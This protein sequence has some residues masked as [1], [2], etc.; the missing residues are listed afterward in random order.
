MRGEIKNCTRL[1]ISLNNDVLA[2]LD[3]RAEQLACPRSV[4]I[5]IA[6]RQKWQT[7]DN[8]ANMPAMLSTLGN[9]VRFLEESKNNPS[10][11]DSPNSSKLLSDTDPTPTK[12]R[13]QK[14]V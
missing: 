7:E 10:L 12:K 1:T 2:E 5:A 8:M 13:R 4:Y 3:R 14:T 6:L 9:A 11:I